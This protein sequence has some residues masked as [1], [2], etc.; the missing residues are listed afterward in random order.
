MRWGTGWTAVFGLMP[1]H[2]CWLQETPRQRVEKP[3]G[4]RLLAGKQGV[5]VALSSSAGVS[6]ASFLAGQSSL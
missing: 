3:G 1:D 5:P 2:T 4:L 6:Y